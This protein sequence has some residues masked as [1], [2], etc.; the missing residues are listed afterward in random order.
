[1]FEIW[2]LRLLNLNYVRTAIDFK[3]YYLPQIPTFKFI[4]G[5]IRI[6]LLHLLID[7]YLEVE[8]EWQFKN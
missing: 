6:D 3:A 8:G 4:C 5:F 7:Q 1:M 2:D